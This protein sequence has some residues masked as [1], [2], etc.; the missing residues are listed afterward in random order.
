[1]FPVKFSLKPIHSPDGD[2]WGLGTWFCRPRDVVWPHL[3]DVVGTKNTKDDSN[4][5]GSDTESV[6]VTKGTL[7]LIL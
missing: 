5:Q 4:L 2:P 3:D 6:W 7:D 1:M